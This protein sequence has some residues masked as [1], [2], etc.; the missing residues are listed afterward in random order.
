MASSDDVLLHQKCWFTVTISQCLQ[1]YFKALS[2]GS[3]ICSLHPSFEV[4]HFQLHAGQHIQIKGMFITKYQRVSLC[5]TSCYL[6]I[7]QRI[8]Q[9]ASTKDD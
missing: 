1:S 5:L 3:T 8:S 6:E 7:F 2:I 4:N 9:H